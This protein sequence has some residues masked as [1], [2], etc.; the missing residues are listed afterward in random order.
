[1]CAIFIQSF[2]AVVDPMFHRSHDRDG[3]LQISEFFNNLSRFFRSCPL[4]EL[5]THDV[6]YLRVCV[7]YL[8]IAGL[9]HDV[10]YHAF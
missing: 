8:E 1:M 2:R 10:F 6:K 9:S 4:G 3:S 5:K 7:R